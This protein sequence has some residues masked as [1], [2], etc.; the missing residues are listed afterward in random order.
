MLLLTTLKDAVAALR[1]IFTPPFRSALLK[2]LAITLAAIVV[3]SLMLHRGLAHVVSPATPWI[4]TIVGIVEGLGL[5]VAAIFLVAPV[6]A[7]VAGF[8]VDDLAD[9]VE[10][11]L[12]PAG[13]RGR[14]LPIGQA[15]LLA[16]RFA[17]LSLL[18]MLA[19]LAL[20]L[21]PGVNGI[22]F[23]AANAYLAGRQ[24]FEF[25]ALRF[26][27]VEE[28]AQLRRAHAG[29][30][31]AAG[32]CIALVLAVPI[33]NLLTPLFGTALMVRTVRRVSRLG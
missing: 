14:A 31:Y 30:V 15:L 18:V 22:V 29:T 32:L 24:Y 5:V 6:S 27:T 26:G 25:A 19:A 21:V 16:M 20:L 4:A 1:E 10:R 3:L 33:L 12:D 8:F 13:P 23:L 7:V 11:D 17:I 9:R 28:V 2:I